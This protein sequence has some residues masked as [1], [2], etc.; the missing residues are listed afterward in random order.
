MSKPDPYAKT[1]H[2]ESCGDVMNR[3]GTLC[4]ECAAESDASNPF[5]VYEDD[6][7]DECNDGF[8]ERLNPMTG[9]EE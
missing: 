1:Y 5:A 6:D 9:E 4:A 3:P 7:C 2:C 8:C